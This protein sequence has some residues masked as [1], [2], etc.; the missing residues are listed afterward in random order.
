[1]EF[2]VVTGMSGAGKSCA[3]DA[4]EDIGFFCVD[5]LPPNLIMAFYSLSKTSD[6]KR[7]AIV[8][9]IRGGSLFSGLIETL[10]TM[11]EEGNDYKLLFFDADDDVLIKRYKE[12]RRKHPLIDMFSGSVEQSIDFEREILNSVKNMADYVIDTTHITTMQLKNRINS[13]F[14]EEPDGSLT[15]QC[16]SFG[17]KYGIPMES[18]L[19]FDVRCLPNPYYVDSLKDKRGTDKEVYDYV[20]DSSK[21]EEVLKRLTELID[22][23]LPLYIEEGKSQLVI[24]IGCTGGHHRSV[25]IAEFLASH[26]KSRYKRIIITH[27]DIKK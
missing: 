17:F 19:V 23:M 26:L 24:S 15:I 1:M 7:V 6:Y 13:M 21:T 20:M 8:T 27:R 22:Y 12:T 2:L 4:L 16:M 5:N 14:L 10:H 25:A 18:D 9:D 11:K 3:I